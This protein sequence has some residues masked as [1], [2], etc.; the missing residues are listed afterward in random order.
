M[1]EVPQ[2]PIIPI[3][4]MRKLK[5]ATLLISLVTLVVGVELVLRHR[6]HKPWQIQKLDKEPVVHSFD[7][8]LG[9]KNKPGNHRIPLKP[10]EPD[11]KEIA[12]TITPLGTRASG[13]K[14]PAAD[15]KF[16]IIGGSYAQGWEVS[17]SETF[18]WKLQSRLPDWEIHNYGTGGFSSYQSLLMMERLLKEYSPTLVTYSFSFE[19]VHRNEDPIRWLSILNRYSKRGQLNMPYALLGPDGELVRKPNIQFSTWPLRENLALV[20][21]LED[22]YI[23]WATERPQ[24]EW[25]KLTQR[26]FLEMRD[27]A[28]SHNTRFLVSLVGEFSTF[29]QGFLDF[30]TNNSIEHVDCAYPFTNEYIAGLDHPN[31]K[32]NSLWADC[33]EMAM[34]SA[35]TTLT[36]SGL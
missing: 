19:H 12:F 36:R 26:I 18:A 34:N 20:K 8:T 5:V 17:D 3:R 2:D 7:T 6:G 1:M 9:W 28:A 32:M 27:L 10:D 35:P 13:V 4:P 23:K 24:S 22:K 15:K 21:Y 14:H 33:I 29:K 31:G 11:S 16:L 30:F 25:G